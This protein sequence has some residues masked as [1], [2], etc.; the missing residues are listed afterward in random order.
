MKRPLTTSI[1]LV[2]A[3]LIAAPMAAADGMEQLVFSAGLTP[4]QASGM[5][6]TEIY[7]HKINRESGRDNQVTVSSREV[8]GFRPSE[9]GQL[10][11]SAGLDA[12]AARGM[13]L[14]EISAAKA[15]RSA[16]TR[17]ERVP[18]PREV[19]VGFDPAEHAQ[20]VAR[21]GLTVEE[22]QG[23]SLSEIYRRKHNGENG[24]DELQR[25]AR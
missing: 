11:A 2:L 4:A 18:M 25:A 1:G 21:A 15:S 3:G 24:R 12:A 10:V 8:S 5:S 22:A 6:L 7:A 14:A 16:A 23:L 17:D 13:S 19:S 20:L 9:H